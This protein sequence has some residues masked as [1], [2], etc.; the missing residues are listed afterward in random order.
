MTATGYWS[1]HW[2]ALQRDTLSNSGLSGC[3]WI[4]IR[5]RHA[6]NTHPK[7]L[8]FL[9]R[10]SCHPSTIMSALKCSLHKNPLLG[11]FVWRRKC[12]VPVRF[13]IKHILLMPRRT[14]LVFSYTWHR[15]VFSLRPIVADCGIEAKVHFKFIFS[16]SQPGWGGKTSPKLNDAVT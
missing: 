16:Y 5:L 6:T 14:H 2:F 9:L 12:I 8:N 15:F 3:S 11:V 4:L 13:Y 1:V 7:K 10:F